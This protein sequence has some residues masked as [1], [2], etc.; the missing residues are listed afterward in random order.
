MA[1][2]QSASQ[3]EANQASSEHLM[4]R[5]SAANNYIASQ[6]QQL[7]QL[8]SSPSVAHNEPPSQLEQANQVGARSPSGGRRSRQQQSPMQLYQQLMQSS[9]SVN[10]GIN[11]GFMSSFLQAEKEKMAPARLN[12]PA[13]E[14]AIEGAASTTTTTPSNLQQ[15]N[16][17]QP[18]KQQGTNAQPMRPMMMM[19]ISMMPDN[20]IGQAYNAAVGQALPLESGTSN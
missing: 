1:V 12:R 5:P 8:M 17:Q 11:H 4:D 7:S 20:M 16:Q 3:F 14:G 9:P 10:H 2:I 13:P 19:P 18:N 6:P 15:T